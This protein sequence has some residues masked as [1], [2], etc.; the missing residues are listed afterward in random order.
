MDETTFRIIMY[1]IL[2]II[3]LSCVIFVNSSREEIIDR[4]IAGM[5]VP[6]EEEK[7]AGEI[8]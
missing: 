2:L 4:E 1:I 8:V 6:E 5:M 7:Y 3:C